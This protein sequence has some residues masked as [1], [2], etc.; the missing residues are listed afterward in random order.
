MTN[1]A[2]NTYLQRQFWAKTANAYL[3]AGAPDAA[4]LEKLL[5]TA[6]EWEAKWQDYLSH[7]RAT[8]TS[9]HLCP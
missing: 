5:T 1:H 3:N 2:D 8:E 4:Y 9:L 7:L 6:A